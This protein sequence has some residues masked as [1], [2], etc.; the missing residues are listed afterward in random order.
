MRLLYWNM[1]YHSEHHVLPQAP[2]F[3]LPE[4]NRLIGQHLKPMGDGLLAVD[5]EVR[6]NCIVSPAQARS[7]VAERKRRNESV[8][9]S[10]IC[11]LD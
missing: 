5:Q 4:V 10:W 9:T 2:F 1:P 7:I 8:D 11:H 3:A 6:R